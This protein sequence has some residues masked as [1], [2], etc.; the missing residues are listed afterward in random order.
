MSEKNPFEDIDAFG[1][2]QFDLTPNQ[3]KFCLLYYETS[4]ATY[5]YREAYGT[6]NPRTAS[7]QGS[8][9]LKQTRIKKRI[10]SLKKKAQKKAGKTIDDMINLNVEIA[11]S[12]LSDVIEV[13]DGEVHL[14]E[15][16]DVDQLDSI[17]FSMS[18]SHNSSEKSESSSKTKSINVKRPDRIKAAQEIAK[19]CGFYD[20][21]GTDAG[22]KKLAAKKLLDAL[23][24]FKKKEN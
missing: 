6:K 20:E 4:N 24:K 10:L 7:N 17:G 22:D 19:L 8:K 1:P 11:F 15:G 12:K 23:T 3:E 18:E 2:P 21:K 16:A 13:I 5:S 14:K 9:L